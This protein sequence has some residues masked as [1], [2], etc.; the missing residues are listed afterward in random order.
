MERAQENLDLSLSFFK[1]N[2]ERRSLW[3][4]RTSQLVT[5][6]ALTPN[7]H[8]SHWTEWPPKTKHAQINNYQEVIES[9]G[10]LWEYI[11]ATIKKWIWSG[12]C[13]P[14][15]PSN[16]FLLGTLTL[17]SQGYMFLLS[18]LHDGAPAIFASISWMNWPFERMSSKW[19]YVYQLSRQ[20][21]SL[22]I[23]FSDADKSK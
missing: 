16:P 4:A 19:G 11:S 5:P 23:L 17:I 9:K 21:L 22:L 3:L 13:G 6:K 10:R 18:L 20:I 7:Q 2:A 8:S 12:L 15:L 14:Y 1:K